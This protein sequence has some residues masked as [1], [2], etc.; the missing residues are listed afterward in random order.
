MITE[1]TGIALS[2][3][4]P[5]RYRLPLLHGNASDQLELN[6]HSL[7]LISFEVFEEIEM[8]YPDGSAPLRLAAQVSGIER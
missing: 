8:E 1:L 3:R 7:W 5:A 4:I 6:S 2:Y